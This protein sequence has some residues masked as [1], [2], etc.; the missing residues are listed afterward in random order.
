MND[1]MRRAHESAAARAC[2]PTQFGL[3]RDKNQTLHTYNPILLTWS[4][5]ARTAKLASWLATCLPEVG[6]LNIK[7]ATSFACIFL[8]Q[9]KAWRKRFWDVKICKPAVE[10]VSNGL[11]TWFFKTKPLFRALFSRLVYLLRCYPEW[12]CIF[13]EVRMVYFPDAR[14]NHVNIGAFLTFFDA[15]F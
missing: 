3:D 5:Y 15:T 10:E 9:I 8:G 14:T 4:A 6:F 7:F 13:L 12:R 11:K 2:T 1:Q